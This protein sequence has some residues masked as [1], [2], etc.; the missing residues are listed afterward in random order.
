MKTKLIFILVVLLAFEGYAQNFKRYA[1]KSGIVQYKYK[2]KTTGTETLYFDDYGRKE[3]KYTHTVSKMFGVKTVEDKIVVLDGATV[4]TYDENT[5]VSSKNINPLLSSLSEDDN[6]DYEE[7]G[8]KTMESLGF[9]KIGTETV[10]GKDCDVWEGMGTIW[11]WKGLAIKT[12]MNMMGVY[13]VIS[14]TDVKTDV[15][16][17][18]KKFVIP[19]DAVINKD[20]NTD[21]T[22]DKNKDAPSGINSLG[23]MFKG[24]S[25]DNSEESKD[26]DNPMGALNSLLD[27]TDD[28]GYSEDFD[29]EDMESVSKG[30]QA[31]MQAYAKQKD[32]TKKVFQSMTYD[33]F[34]KMVLEEESNVTEKEIREAY[35]E[36]Q[37]MLKENF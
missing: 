29:E 5:G 8:L 26:C 11:V 36:L 24:I 19:A 9:K 15:A 35:N 30:M 27:N 3:A 4:I 31:I 32:S 6:F 12:E 28:S 2:G 17:P 18:A 7:F 25:D 33:D 21:N 22:S 16:V 13:F 10:L 1:F 34:K 37:E 20:V 23:N 14:A